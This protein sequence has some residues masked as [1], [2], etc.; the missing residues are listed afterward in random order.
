MYGARVAVSLLMLPRLNSVAARAIRTVCVSLILA[1][2]AG[3]NLGHAET[4]GVVGVL[5]RD[6]SL[7]TGDRISTAAAE[8]I[9]RS[10]Y[11]K[12]ARLVIPKGKSSMPITAKTSFETTKAKKT[13]K[14]VI[15]KRRFEQLLISAHVVQSAIGLDKSQVQFANYSGDDKANNNLWSMGYGGRITLRQFTST[16]EAVADVFGKNSSKYAFECATAAHLIYLNAIKDRIGS[17]KFD[18]AAPRLSVFRWVVR[19]P[20][21]WDDCSMSDKHEMSATDRMLTRLYQAAAE[22]GTQ[23]GATAESDDAVEGAML[24]ALWNDCQGEIK[25]VHESDAGDKHEDAETFLAL[26]Y[27]AS[28]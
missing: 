4:L 23:R 6:G 16:T 25:K 26:I 28:E 9:L 15:G 20:G 14:Q 7:A 11:G 1:L 3:G 17:K 27:S 13:T 24:A 5:E 22:I 21:N 8:A 18:A 12:S 19:D 2:L 10:V